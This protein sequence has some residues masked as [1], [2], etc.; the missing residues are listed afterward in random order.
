MS[1]YRF[2][3]CDP[4]AALYDRYQDGAVNRGGATGQRQ[5]DN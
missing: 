4:V 2:R 1:N 3:T 5:P